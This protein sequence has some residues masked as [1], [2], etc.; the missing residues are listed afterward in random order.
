MPTVVKRKLK[1][2]NFLRL[3]GILIILPVIFISIIDFIS[4]KKDTS[5][6]KKE[7]SKIHSSIKVKN[8]VDDNRTTVIEPSV[9]I[10]KFD[11]YYNYIN[12]S[13]IDVDFSA[14][15]KMNSDAIGYLEIKGTEISL[16]IVF[17]EDKTYYQTHSFLKKENRFG[18]PQL[19]SKY[20]KELE[21]I[22]IIESTNETLKNIKTL[23][24]KEWQQNKNNHV[25]KYVT[26][27]YTSLW[28]IIG[29]DKSKENKEINIDEI[30]T[31]SLYDFKTFVN[32]EDQI[33]ILKGHTGKTNY[34]VYAKLIKYKS[35]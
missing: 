4:W 29:I 30:I 22:T 13:L 17:E 26:K 23:F 9:E 8:L 32:E 20:N 33:L 15:Q 18:W 6:I 16:P 25:I 11:R 35:N 31:N 12:M 14:L 5:E 21:D 1:K 34:Y 7:L 19:I 3:L 24:K 27:D 2:K 28:Q 10:S